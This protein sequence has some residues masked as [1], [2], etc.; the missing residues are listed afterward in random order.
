MRER[1][2][3]CECTYRTA[4]ITSMWNAQSSASSIPSAT[5]AAKGTNR[6]YLKVPMSSQELVQRAGF[7]RHR[8]AW[9]SARAIFRSTSPAAATRSVFLR[10]ERLAR[11]RARRASGRDGSAAGARSRFGR[12]ARQ[13][14]PRE[15]RDRLGASRAERATAPMPQTLQPEPAKWIAGPD[16][17]NP[18]RAGP[19]ETARSRG[20]RAR[21]ALRTRG[22]RCPKTSVS[23]LVLGRHSPPRAV[24]A[25]ATGTREE[26]PA[27]R[28]IGSGKACTRVSC[29]WLS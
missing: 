10:N 9:G 20:V 26:F 16:A 11:G 19:P 13:A 4:A 17:R 28:A 18:E 21:L 5:V 2:Q 29:E 15:R 12:L 23:E 22:V 25:R 8:A 1:C 3:N 6:R 7:E 27:R 14:G 24:A